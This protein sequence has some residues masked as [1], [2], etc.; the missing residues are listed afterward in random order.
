LKNI[1][2]GILTKNIYYELGVIISVASQRGISL[3]EPCDFEQIVDQ[4]TLNDLTQG[5]HKYNEKKNLPLA[6]C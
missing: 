4:E 2:K 3:E 5:A 1:A 6:S